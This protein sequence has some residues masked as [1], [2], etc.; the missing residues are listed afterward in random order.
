MYTYVLRPKRNVPFPEN[1][2][3]QE[4]R[5]TKGGKRKKIKNKRGREKKRKKERK[6]TRSVPT[7]ATARSLSQ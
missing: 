3:E 6:N 2:G 1:F 7:T 5:K 4:Q